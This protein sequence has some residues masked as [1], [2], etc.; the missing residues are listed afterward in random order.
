MLRAAVQQISR[1]VPG[2]RLTLLSLYPA[3]DAAENRDPALKIA[4]LSPLSMVAVAFPLALLAGLLRRLRLPYRFLLRTP[5]LRA[6]DAADLVI[7]LSG[8]SFV[9][10]RGTIIIYNVLVVLL[11]VLL[12]KPL[13]KYAQALGP[14]RGRLNRFCA[15]WLLP[16]TARIVARGRITRAHLD[17]LGLPPELVVDSTDAA[18]AMEVD[19]QAQA[20]VEALRRERAFSRP[21]VA[22]SASSVVERLCEARGIDYPARMVE[23]I[24]WLIDEKGYGVC[25]VAHSA[26]PG[27]ESVKNNDL[28]VCRRIA[29]EV[30]RDFC[31][32]PDRALNAGE[33]RAL[34]GSCR[35]LVAA[36]FHAMIAGLATGT[37]TLQVGWSH[38]YTEVLELFDLQEY[39]L[40]YARVTEAGLREMFERVEREETEIRA[41]LAD[42]LPAV[43]ELS[44]INARLA[45]ELLGGPRATTSEPG[46]CKT[47]AKTGR[48]L[49]LASTLAKV[50][51]LGCCFAYLGAVLVRNF[52]DLQAARQTLRLW[53][54][55][56]SFPLAVL[57]LIGRGLVWHLMVRR[58]VGRFSAGADVRCWLSS[59]LG[60]YLPG[61]VFALLGR[62]YMYQSNGVRSAQVTACFLLEAACAALAA[63][64]IAV[65]GMLWTWGP[66]RIGALAAPAALLVAGL[67]IATHPGVLGRLMNIGLR[68]AGRSPIVLN[69]RWHDVAGWT[70]L[71]AVNWLGLGLGFHLLLGALT[72]APAHL[73]VFLTGT[74]AAAGIIGILAIF[75]PAGLGVR[76]GV[77]TALLATV[78]PPGIAVAAALLTRLWMTLA[79][80]GCAGVA[81]LLGRRAT[82]PAAAPSR[83]L[84]HVPG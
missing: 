61:K 14:F 57:Y 75:A 2:V 64:L 53:P 54:I 16:K 47:P 56:A 20:A 59:L 60:K 18:F 45:A 82:A 10:G 26:R 40:D 68:M 43:I 3:D 41:K 65:V 55:I 7:D 51:V 25:L 22:V 71:M 49:K 28:P 33:L 69:V 39:A 8:I 29:R 24:R 44:L 17:E 46:P 74:F 38:K 36:R 67:I 66:D 35:F 4:P 80:A 6:L 32:F 48:P 81:L 11:P 78:L 83:E 15:R 63:L 37:P 42:V 34:I 5:A 27:R 23:L 1:L 50:L 13:L 12:G 31:C 76:E 9:D 52:E 58:M 73:Y 70:A 72:A 79:E 77:M 62:L 30:G 21:V 19:P 84:E